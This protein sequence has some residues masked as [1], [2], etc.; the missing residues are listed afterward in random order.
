MRVTGVN[1]VATIDAASVH[2]ELAAVGKRIFHG[3]GVK[4]LVHARAAATALAIMPPAERLGLDRPGVLHPAEM[5]DMVDVKVAETPAAR[6]KE[7]VEALNLPEQFSWFARPFSRECRSHRSM[8]PVAAQQN[9]IAD[10]AVLNALIQFL[11]R[12]A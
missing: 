1:V 9:E 10:F 4:I 2:H 11:E 6:P 7:T 5:V 3:I 12:P 8:H